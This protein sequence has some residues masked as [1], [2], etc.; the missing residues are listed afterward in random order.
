MTI[1]KTPYGSHVFPL[2]PDKQ[3]NIRDA[4]YYLPLFI[5]SLSGSNSSP[6]LTRARNMANFQETNPK[7]AGRLCLSSLHRR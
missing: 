4:L 7:N 3:T 5:Q 2:T 1:I 6:H